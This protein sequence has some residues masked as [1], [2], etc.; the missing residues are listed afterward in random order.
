MNPTPII[1]AIYDFFKSILK[2]VWLRYRIVLDV[3]TV[4][5][6]VAVC[7]MLWKG[8]SPDVVVYAGPPDSSSARAGKDV[9]AELRNTASPRGIHY[10]ARIVNTTGF[11]DIR[12]RLENSDDG[13]AVGFLSELESGWPNQEH[14][15]GNCHRRWREWKECRDPHF[16]AWQF[17]VSFKSTCKKKT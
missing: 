8:S 1:P 9:A 12:Q 6:V 2:I 16:S 11:D 10:R 14:W 4:A 17:G 15:L 7:W 5:V 13:I 3:M